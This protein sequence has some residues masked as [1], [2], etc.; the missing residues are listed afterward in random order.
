[1]I[2]L[3]CVILIG[4]QAFIFAQEEVYLNYTLPPGSTIMER[5][6]KTK[7]IQIDLPENIKSIYVAVSYENRTVANW[8]I[9]RNGKTLILVV[10]YLFSGIDCNGLTIFIDYSYNAD[11]LDDEASGL[12]MECIDHLSSSDFPDQD[13][14]LSDIEIPFSSWNTIISYKSLFPSISLD[15]SIFLSTEPL[16]IETDLYPQPI[17]P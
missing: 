16:P 8:G 2:K 3:I 12:R 1:M 11:F 14:Y 5:L 13:P 10:G 15:Y 7:S 6:G 4:F 17:H 9:P